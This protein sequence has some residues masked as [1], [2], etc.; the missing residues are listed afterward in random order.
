M[1]IA[2]PATTR[3][4]AIAVAQAF[5]FLLPL[6]HVT[7]AHAQGAPPPPGGNPANPGGPLS[8]A[9]ATGAPAFSTVK[10]PL[11]VRTILTGKS[12]NAPARF[13]GAIVCST[14]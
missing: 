4:L 12:T 1:S 5:A 7:I 9:P 10:T 11:T 2:H 14:T 13:C 3:H 8:G 6:V